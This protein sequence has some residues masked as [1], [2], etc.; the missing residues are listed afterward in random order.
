MPDQFDE[1]KQG[2]QP[3]D[4][5]TPN[6][7]EEWFGHVTHCCPICNSEHGVRMFCHHCH[8]DHH[9]DGWDTCTPNDGIETPQ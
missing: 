6:E 5:F 2:R 9:T 4:N 1:Y 8:R 7:R 3:C